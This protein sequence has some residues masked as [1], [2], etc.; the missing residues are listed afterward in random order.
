M[1]K[2]KIGDMVTVYFGN[3]PMIGP[4]VSIDEKRQKY[5]VRFNPHQQMYYS[6]AELTPYTQPTRAKRG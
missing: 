4:V 1:N 6:E 3:I 2:Y 5:L